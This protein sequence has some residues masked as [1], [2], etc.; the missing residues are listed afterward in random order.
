MTVNFPILK[1]LIV[2]DE[3]SK[4]D[5]WR[6]AI[7][8]H[9]ADAERQG[10]SI[11]YVSAKTVNHAKE[12]LEWHRFDAAV[13]D[14]RLQKEVGVADNNS[15]GNLVVRYLVSLQPMGVAV[16]TGQSAD[17]E[18]DS[19]ESSQVKVMD[20]GDGF[21]Q[22]FE[23]L[24]TNLEVFVKLRG[25]KAIYNRET[26]KIF[27]RSIWPRWQ[28]W[29]NSGGDLTEVVARHMIAHVHDALLIA[30]GDSTHPEEAYFI[31]PMKNRLDTG[32]L[33][34]YKDRIWIVV[35]PRCDL[36]NEGKVKTILIAAC[37]DIST[38][39]TALEE[40]DSNSSK[41]K[42]NKIIQHNGSPKQHFLLPMRDLSAQKKGPWMVQFDDICALA[43]D[44]ALG[45]LLPNRIASLSPMF[46]PSLVERFGGYFSR[47]GTPG[48]SSE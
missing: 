30:G 27:Y 44:V 39:W 47:I 42:I 16:Y 21:D 34:N 25:V 22:V 26:A 29:S 24:R 43:P 8:A 37:E 45:E 7:D 28:N 32:D 12:L 18:V 46:V 6:D 9:N 36:A 11:S 38:Q 17:A 10:Y 23:W 20:K 4:L 13:V 14:L 19:Y 5:E 33:V 15:D 48:L 31:P 40:A 1:M 35:S 2:E 41:A 3:D